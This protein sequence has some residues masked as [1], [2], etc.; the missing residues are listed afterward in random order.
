MT[1]Y[2]LRLVGFLEIF[3]F[4]RSEYNIRARWDHCINDG[5]KLRIAK[6]QVPMISSRFL[7]EVVPTI[8]AETTINQLSY[9]LKDYRI[10]EPTFFRQSPS[11]SNLGHWN[12]PFLGYLLNSSQDFSFLIQRYVFPNTHLLI[13][14]STPLTPSNLDRKWSVWPRLVS[15]LCCNGR[16]KRPRPRGDH[17]IEPTPKCYFSRGRVMH[18]VQGDQDKPT[19]L[20]WEWASFHVPLHDKWGCNGSA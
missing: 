19:R 4:L 11:N 17:G 7:I 16:V 3:D 5:T 13:I 8:G 1:N 14:S 10:S 18:D 12:T 6:R 2:R 20:L 15:L 9:A